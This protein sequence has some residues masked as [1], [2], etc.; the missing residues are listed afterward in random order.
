MFSFFL[1]NIL[2]INIKQ[3]RLLIVF[4][5]MEVGFHVI[6]AL[7]WMCLRFSGVHLSWFLPVRLADIKWIMMETKLGQGKKGLK[8]DWR[9]I[10]GVY[11]F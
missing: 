10:S 9:Q 5:S 6:K 11:G 1:W 4:I 2:V 3:E 7:F 8:S